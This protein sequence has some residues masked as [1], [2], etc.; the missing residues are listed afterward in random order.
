MQGLRTP[1]HRK[2][3]CSSAWLFA[4]KFPGPPSVSSKRQRCHLILNA[5]VYKTFVAPAVAAMTIIMEFFGVGYDTRRRLSSSS[6]THI[7]CL[8]L[9]L[10]YMFA[11]MAILFFFFRMWRKDMCFIRLSLLSISCACTANTSR[12]SYQALHHAYPLDIRFSDTGICF[13]IFLFWSRDHELSLLY[14]HISCVQP[15]HAH[16]HHE[17]HFCL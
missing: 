11:S 10:C 4:A 6:S 14:D 15:S 7:N 16:F 17:T 13:C 8:R 1:V 2:S 9:R 12:N 3:P 5:R